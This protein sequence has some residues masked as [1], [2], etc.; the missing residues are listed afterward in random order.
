MDQ[1]GTFMKQNIHKHQGN[2]C[3]ITT[4]C[5]G[6]L[7]QTTNLCNYHFPFKQVK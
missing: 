1:I 5:I 4:I 3:H 6:C 2:A 7:V